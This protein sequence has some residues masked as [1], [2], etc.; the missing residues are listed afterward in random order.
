LREKAKK[1]KSCFQKEG[2]R[3]KGRILIIDDDND[4]LTTL[5]DVLQ[6]KGYGVDLANS[7]KEAIMTAREQLFDI[8]LIDLKL[9][10][11][12]GITV[13]QIFQIKYPDMIKS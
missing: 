3:M 2:E 13:L 12:S 8:A 7:G 9:P 4:M 5:G 6:D 11:M 1:A 10:D